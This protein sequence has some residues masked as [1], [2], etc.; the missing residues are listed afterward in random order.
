[1]GGY[2]ERLYPVERIVG[3]VATGTGGY[4]AGGVGPHGLTN[5]WSVTTPTS[6]A[7]AIE[8]AFVYVMRETV[9]APVGQTFARVTAAGVDLLYANQIDNAVGGKIHQW[10]GHCG[11]LKAGE[12][13]TGSTFDGSTGGTNTLAV[14]CHL[15]QFAV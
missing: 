7:Y 15:R 12:I 6:A 3:G 9:A 1:M 4:N 14:A 11:F 13:I 8:S 5:R 2:H 10:L